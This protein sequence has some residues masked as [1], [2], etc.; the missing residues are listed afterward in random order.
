MVEFR[1]NTHESGIWYKTKRGW[2]KT[3][4]GEKD[5]MDNGK[6]MASNRE[7]VISS[8]LSSVRPYSRW[9]SVPYHP[10]ASQRRTIFSIFQLGF[11]SQGQFRLLSV[12]FL[13][14]HIVWP[15]FPHSSVKKSRR[16]G[17]QTC[18]RMAEVITLTL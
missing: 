10:F 1:L 3:V 17:F 8:L 4:Q 13:N 15:V 9:F 11:T 6:R 7:L 12:F 5:G 18:F 2:G 16:K 14:Y